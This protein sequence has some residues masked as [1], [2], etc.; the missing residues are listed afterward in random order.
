MTWKTVLLKDLLFERKNRFKPSD[1]AI[2]NYRRVDKIDFSGKIHL[3]DK[4]SNT[5][6][7]LVKKGDLLISGIN[8][9]K[10][11]LAVYEGNE[12]VVATIHYSSY[13]F[14]ER[15][16]SINFLKA[17]LKSQNFLEALKQQVPGG[18]KTE[19]KPKHLLP[20]KISIPD[21]VEEQEALMEV[22]LQ[23]E[24]KV[25]ATQAE[26]RTQR[27]LLTQLRQAILQ[28]A[29]QGKL[30]A[31]WRQENQTTNG[32][33]PETGADLLARIRAEKADLI[34][35]GKLRKEKPLPPITDVEKPFELPD[36]W[37]WCRLGE[38]SWSI[39]TGPFGTMLH[40]SDYIQNGIPV[41]NPMNIVDSVIVPHWNM[42]VSQKIADTCCA[43]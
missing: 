28:E 38:I 9:H 11:A 1:E 35:Q 22:Y 14:N 41:V 31:Q 2:A 39:S 17:F 18:I 25:L 40:K 7:I 24:V 16:I 37:V 21:T 10:G 12:D 33:Q 15:K 8:V 23:K 5:D 29:V 3:S 13:Q 26:L 4:S 6:M 20:L 27:T 19:I 36:G 42:T 32:S 30:T 43:T 34:S